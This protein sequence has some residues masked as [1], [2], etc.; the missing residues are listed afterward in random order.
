MHKHREVL[1][2]NF[3]SSQMFDLVADIKKYPLFLPWCI[4]ARILTEK[5][6]ELTAELAIEFARFSTSY[7]SKV[8]LDKPN[9]ILVELLEGPFEYLTNK[10]EF[11][12]IGTKKC[13]IIFEIEFK[14]RTN[15]FQKLMDSLFEKAVNKMTKAFLERA[16]E[17]YG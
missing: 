16:E 3:S 10:W 9:L 5:N 6:N 13:Q 8:T 2:V 17:I 7:I 1:E 12:E 14:F 11:I 15:L 4:A